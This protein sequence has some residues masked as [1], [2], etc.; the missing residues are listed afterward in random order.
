MIES[1]DGYIFGGYTK[2]SWAGNGYFADSYAFLF[3]LVNTGGVA[4][5]LPVRNSGHAIQSASTYGP[6]FGGDIYFYNDLN[7]FGLQLGDK[8][9]KPNDLSG[10][11]A[12]RFF[13]GEGPLTTKEVEVFVVY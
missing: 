12:T 13:N 6:V 1:T 10:V 3:T 7:S 8:Y 4:L 11:A 5:K 9:T 2:K